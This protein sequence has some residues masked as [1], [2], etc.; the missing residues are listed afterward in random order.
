MALAVISAE[1]EFAADLLAAMRQGRTAFQQREGCHYLS[2]LELKLHRKTKF[3]P[4][5]MPMLL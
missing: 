3:V 5:M 4:L 2:R 1:I